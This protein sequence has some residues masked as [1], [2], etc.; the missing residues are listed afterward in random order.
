[1]FNK[2]LFM[3]VRL[4]FVNKN[5]FTRQPEFLGVEGLLLFSQ[6]RL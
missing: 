3:F 4:K 5:V 2:A 6:T 1:M